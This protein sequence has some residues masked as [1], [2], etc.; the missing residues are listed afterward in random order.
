MT[1]TPSP[2]N[3]TVVTV[4]HPETLSAADILG[5][6]STIANADAPLVFQLVPSPTV[7][8]A[9]TLGQLGLGIAQQIASL[10]GALHKSKQA[11][12]AA[13][14]NALQFSQADPNAAATVNNSPALAAGGV[15]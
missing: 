11:V 8:I 5:A 14:A 6:V 3:P 10:I 13:K 4:A 9:F 1:P 12:A 15:I 7:Q 2:N